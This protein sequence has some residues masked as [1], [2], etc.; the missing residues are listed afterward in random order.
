MDLPTYAR[1]RRGAIPQLARRVRISAPF[2]WQCIS[3]A[4]RV[5]AGRCPSLELHSEGLMTAE[6]LRPDVRWLRVPDKRWPRH[7]GGRPVPDL[8]S[9]A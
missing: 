7:L 1:T 3:G 2:L 8:T 9:A 5:P 6:E 4:R